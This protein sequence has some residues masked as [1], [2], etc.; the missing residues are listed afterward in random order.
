MRED[1]RAPASTRRRGRNH[2][3]RERWL[4][5][6]RTA[7]LSW[8]VANGRDFPWRRTRDP[9]KLLIAEILLRQTQARRV[10]GPYR[11][12]VKKFPN[13]ASLARAG[14]AE[15][16]T[17]FRPLGLVQRAD[18]L[19]HAA[20]ILVDEHGG[21][22]PRNLEDLV[23]L[24]GLGTYSARAVMCLAFEEPLPMVDESSGR[25]LRRLV[26][27]PDDGPAYSS[28]KLLDLAGSLVPARF[29]RGFNLGLL[30]V[31]A[32]CCHVQGPNCSPCPLKRYCTYA[33]CAH[34][35]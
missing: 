29:A 7:V 22:V 23:R 6:V 31:A 4:E 18:R 11:E 27:W 8:S 25:L 17:I 20:R 12:L 28:K 24:P 14:Q 34:K 16:R 35:W 2:T 9:Y 21:R 32:A 26:G 33:R 3:L 30:D 13:P 15:V 1:R 10:I 19:L 5:G